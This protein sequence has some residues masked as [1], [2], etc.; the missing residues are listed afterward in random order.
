MPDLVSDDLVVGTLLDKTD[1]LRLLPLIHGIQRLSFKENGAAPSAMRRE[2]CFQL[3]QQ[4]GLSAAGGSAKYQKFSLPDSQAHVP[5]DSPGLLRI[6][7]AKVF[8]YKGVCHGIF[9]LFRSRTCW[10]STACTRSALAREVNSWVSHVG[11]IR[12]RTGNMAG[13]VQGRC[14]SI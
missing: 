5:Q 6:G 3:P 12:S 7:K 9:S 11:S 8:N 1:S 13:S 10:V 4:R 14:W 2:N